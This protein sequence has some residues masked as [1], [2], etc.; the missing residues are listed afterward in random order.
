M[1]EALLFGDGSLLESSSRRSA[2]GAIGD[3]D[4]SS[5]IDETCRYANCP[6]SVESLGGI[7]E[8]AVAL[9]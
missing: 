7:R 6:Q 3:Q 2:L 5:W 8:L 9:E 4:S 1:T